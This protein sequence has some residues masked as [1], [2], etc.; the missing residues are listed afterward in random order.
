M[1]QCNALIKSND[2]HL[3]ADKYRSSI[4]TDVWQGGLANHLYV[5]SQSDDH[6]IY[7]SWK[8]FSIPLGI[9]RLIPKSVFR[10]SYFELF[11]MYA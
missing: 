3:I 8:L 9:C 5:M 2:G 6:I 4:L 11:K 10:K 7:I 1:P